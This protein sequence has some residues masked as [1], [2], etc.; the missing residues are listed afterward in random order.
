MQAARGGGDCIVQDVPE[1][2]ELRTQLPETWLVLNE[3]Q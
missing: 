3:A 1:R 2:G